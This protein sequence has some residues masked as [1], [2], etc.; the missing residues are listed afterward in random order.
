M[1]LAD[2]VVVLRDGRVEQIGPPLALDEAPASAFVFDFLGDSNRLAC[3]IEGARAVFD[4]YSTPATVRD[5]V[6][7]KTIAWFRPHETLIEREGDGLP[8]TVTATGIKGASARLECR[9]GDGA[10]FESHYPRD[11][12]QSAFRVGARAVLRPARVFVFP[13]EEAT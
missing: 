8:V 6:R 1:D 4:G 5:G 7:G 12:P 11:A 9:S 13:D 10:L 2:R 3:R